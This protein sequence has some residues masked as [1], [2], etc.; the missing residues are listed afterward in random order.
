MPLPTSDAREN[1]RLGDFEIVREIGRGGMGVVYEARQVSLNRRVALKV[2]LGGIGLDPESVQRFQ[3]EAEAAGK[4]HH[5]NIVPVYASGKENGTYFFAMEVIDG[6]SL[7]QVIRQRRQQP[8]GGA[9]PGPASGTGLASSSL[10][11]D[12]GYFEQAAESI[13]EVADALD[14]AH[15]QGVIHRDIKPANLLLSPDGRLSLSDFGLARLLEQPALTRTGELGGTPAYMSPEQ[16][17]AG[18]VPLNHRT[19]IYS[20]GATL[21]EMLT[22]QRP[23]TGETREQLLAQILQKDPPPPRRVNPRIPVDLETICLKAMDKDPDRRYQTAGQMAEDL[24]RFGKRLAIS[25]RRP[26][27]VERLMKWARR[28]PTAATAAGLIVLALGIAGFFAWQAHRSGQ[29]LRQEKARAALDLAMVAAMSGDLDRAESKLAVAEQLGAGTGQA[30]L[31]RGMVELYRGDSDGAARILRQTVKE[32]PDSL[33]AHALLGAAY[34]HQ[35]NLVELELVERR[36]QQLKPSTPEDI[37]F[38]AL[39]MSISEPEL[40]KA[41][42]NDPE[43]RRNTSVLARAVRAEVLCNYAMFTGKA[44]AAE[45]AVEAAERLSD[46]LPESPVTLKNIVMAYLVLASAQEAAGHLDLRDRAFEKAGA[47]AETL[48]AF[49]KSAVASLARYNYFERRDRLDEAEAVC[50]QARRTAGGFQFD[51]LLAGILYRKG[52]LERARMILWDVKRKGS[53]PVTAL[54]YVL[55][56]LGEPQSVD[57]ILEASDR[58]IPTSIGRLYL[59]TVADFSGRRDAV[60]RLLK[61]L[62]PDQMAN[63]QHGWYRH[64]LAYSQRDLKEEAL[65]HL[66]DSRARECEA[67]FFIA[68]RHL[69]EGR[70]DVARLHFEKSAGTHMLGYNDYQWSRAFL[71][72]IEKTEKNGEDWPGWIKPTK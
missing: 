14:Y 11:P 24:R 41:L 15:K 69:G 50:E 47:A 33:A 46:V 32:M 51:L 58:E 49:P 72:R 30:R 70:R 19:D 62:K 8:A 42:V 43:F 68:M 48:K 4:L 16:V 12:R 9:A 25:A 54:C 13:A 55:T 56:D 64:L 38:R 3:R 23:F 2:L 65:L 29:E 20:L 44:D 63:R 60:V 7:A 52:E 71:A 35:Q 36:A 61:P 22:L 10:G 6:P 27:P 26:G 18:R 67:H 21:Y 45:A 1:Q 66:A 37:V 53:F 31:V 57:Q 40:G 39:L 59:Y 34:L 17:T 5:T 28:H